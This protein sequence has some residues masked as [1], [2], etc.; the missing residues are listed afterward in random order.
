MI[1]YV[2]L[3][4][5]RFEHSHS[6]EVGRARGQPVKRSRAA[7]TGSAQ[8]GILVHLPSH[9]CPSTGTAAHV[10]LAQLIASRSANSVACP[11]YNSRRR[12][13]SIQSSHWSSST[14]RKVKK[15]H[16]SQRANERGAGL[17]EIHSP[18]TTHAVPPAAQ[19]RR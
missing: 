6:N 17:H 12:K 10:V 5:Q 13:H 1:R 2:L 11:N 18:R 4:V 14:L 3:D 19:A 9:H 7:P 8:Y 15:R 16:A